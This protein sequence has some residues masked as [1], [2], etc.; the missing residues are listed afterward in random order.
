MKVKEIL[1]LDSKELEKMMT[2][3]QYDKMQKLGLQYTWQLLDMMQDGVKQSDMNDDEE[4]TTI[5]EY[6]SYIENMR[7]VD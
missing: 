1:D 5:D 3:E 4:Y 2:E 7:D 6:L